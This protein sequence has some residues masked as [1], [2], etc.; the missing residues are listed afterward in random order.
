MNDVIFELTF[1]KNGFG[2]FLIAYL[3]KDM[4]IDFTFP[5]VVKS[6]NRRKIEHNVREKY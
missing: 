6:K 1:I 3:N 5:A 4:N 2:V